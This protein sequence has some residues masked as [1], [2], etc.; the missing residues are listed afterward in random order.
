MTLVFDSKEKEVKMSYEDYN[1]SFI[2]PEILL[3]VKLFFFILGR[4]KLHE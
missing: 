2:A 1:D 4:K 3:N